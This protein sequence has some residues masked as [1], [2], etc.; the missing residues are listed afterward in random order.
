MKSKV[1][2]FRGN[3]VVEKTILLKEI[4]RNNTREYQ[5]LK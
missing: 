5:V 1:I 4:Q 3:Q 2:I